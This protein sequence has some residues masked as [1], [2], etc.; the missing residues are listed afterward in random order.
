MSLQNNSTALN[1]ILFTIENR[2]SRTVYDRIRQ[3]GIEP[4]LDK[5]IIS[6]VEGSVRFITKD[7][8]ECNAETTEDEIIGKVAVGIPLIHGYIKLLLDV[9]N[10]LTLEDLIKD[11]NKILEKT[12]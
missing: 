1:K 7:L 11:I 10:G 8:F 3:E 2:F 6:I 12:K 4:D 5:D 9:K